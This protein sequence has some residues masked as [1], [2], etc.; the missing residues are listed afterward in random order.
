VPSKSTR[1]AFTASMAGA[2]PRLAAL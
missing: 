1:S 2:Y